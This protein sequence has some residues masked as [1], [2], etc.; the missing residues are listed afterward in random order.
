MNRHHEKIL[1]LYSRALQDADFETISQIMTQAASDPDLKTLL[2]DLEAA[3]QSEI[4][5]LAAPPVEE[6]PMIDTSLS[7]NGYRPT[8]AVLPRHP[9]APRPWAFRAAILGV[10]LLAAILFAR[11]TLDRSPDGITTTRIAPNP[12]LFGQNPTPV[13]LAGHPAITA[14][15]ARQLAEVR[16]FGTG[17]VYSMAWSPDSQTLLYAGAGLWFYDAATFTAIRHLDTGTYILDAAYSPDGTRIATANWDGT[18][19]LYDVASGAEQVV[20]PAYDRWAAQVVFSPDG[21]L[22]A[23]SGGDDNS[24]VYVWDAV[25]GRERLAFYDIRDTVFD[26]KFSPDGS[27]LAAAGLA[28]IF[29]DDVYMGPQMKDVVIVWDIPGGDQVFALYGPAAQIDQIAFHPDGQQ[30]I[31]ASWDG[32]IYHWSLERDSRRGTPETRLYDEKYTDPKMAALGSDHLGM[33]F[34]LAYSPDGTWFVS[35]HSGDLQLHFWQTGKVIGRYDPVPEGEAYWS[36]AANNLAF[37]P[38]GKRLLITAQRGQAVV[39]DTSDLT[40]P[41]WLATLGDNH[42][43]AFVDVALSPDGSLV[44]VAESNRGAWLWE[45]NTGKPV[46]WLDYR[47]G[48]PVNDLAFT[49]DGQWLALAQDPDTVYYGSSPVEANYPLVMWSSDP[50]VDPL[51]M[52]EA[53]GRPLYT[54]AFSADGT[55]LFTGGDGG[56]LQAW[57]VL[58][59]TKVSEMSINPDLSFQSK[60]VYELAAN[61]AGSVVAFL[62]LSRS[63]RLWDVVNNIELPALAGLSEGGRA[64]AFSPD[65]S[66]LAAVDQGG[67]LI[68]W[69]SATWAETWYVPDAGGSSA[70][71]FSPDGSLLALAGDSGVTLWDVTARQQVFSLTQQPG[72]VYGLAFSADGTLLATAGEE[73]IVRLW[74]VP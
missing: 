38:D 12:V 73:G 1:Y 65:G 69:D 64:L 74:A 42:N 21:S 23:S 72:G 32:V 59:R 52:T 37:S 13:P 31:A 71:A 3:Y 17:S 44:A 29:P 5:G 27:L 18:I 57:D 70:I 63:V 68:V 50:G 11:Y 15:N 55:H 9:A 4:Q 60:R 22:I 62:D 35:F 24:T 54:L 61:P 14:E 43:A 40:A 30:L 48:P 26:L 49:P 39:W 25:T 46:T 66:Q 53:G 19:R 2:F 36:S 6:I 28:R 41:R 10:V 8:P 16:R 33:V 7:S 67:N 20:I 34:G 51:L 47:L 56:R 45:A 58:S